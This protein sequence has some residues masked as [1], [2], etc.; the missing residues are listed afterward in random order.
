MVYCLFM[1]RENSNDVFYITYSKWKVW[2]YAILCWVIA[3]IPLLPVLLFSHAFLTGR[4]KFSSDYIL[5]FIFCFAG[6]FLFA[7]M[8][9]L[10]L[11]KLKKPIAILTR[12]EFSVLGKS[13][14]Q[15]FP[16][17]PNTVTCFV[18][19]NLI[20]A[21]LDANQSRASKLLRGPKAKIGIPMLFAKQKDQ[22]FFDAID[23]LSP[24]PV[25]RT[26]AWGASK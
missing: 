17:S 19:S 11:T 7:S 16:W 14:D 2:A 10:F 9:F 24:Y 15:R 20:I 18:K 5:L 4:D 23:R 26:S 3:C 13:K 12:T 22:E 21:N 8:P 6:F 1:G 25:K